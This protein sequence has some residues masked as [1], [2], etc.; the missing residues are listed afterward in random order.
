MVAVLIVL[1]S[2]PEGAALLGLLALAILILGKGL[3]ILGGL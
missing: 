1:A 3:S 2:Y